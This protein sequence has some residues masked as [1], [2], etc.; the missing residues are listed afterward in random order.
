MARPATSLNVPGEIHG[1]E[2]IRRRWGLIIVV[3]VFRVLDSGLLFLVVIE[4]ISVV[5]I[6]VILFLLI[7]AVPVLVNGPATYVNTGYARSL[8]FKSCAEI[9]N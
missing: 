6:N 8:T 5:V 7:V 9:Q 3:I 4:V 1:L 2:E